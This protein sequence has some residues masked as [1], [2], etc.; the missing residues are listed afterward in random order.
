MSLLS[1]HDIEKSYGAHQVLKGISVTLAAG[2]R[3]GIVGN[4]GSGKTTLAR[5]LGKIEP[6][7]VGVVMQ[8]RGSRIGYLAQVP[9]LD[10][11]ATVRDTAL[12]GLAEFTA[13]RREHESVSRALEQLAER[14][15]EAPSAGPSSESL[16]ER[17]AELDAGIERMGGWAQEH[18][19]NS[20]LERLHVNQLDALIGT[21]SGGERRRVALC[22][23]LVSEPDVL[24]LDEPT[25]HLDTDSIDWLEEYLVDAYKGGVVVITHDRYFLDRVV[26]R[27][28]EVDAGRLQSYDGG[29]EAYLTAKAERQALEARTESNRQNFLRTE[30]EWLRR[31][32]KA[33][34]T[35]QKARIQ[36]AETAIG[37]G[38]RGGPQSLLF[39]ATSRRQGS[40][41]LEFSKVKAGY[42][43]RVLI[44]GLDLIVTPGQR[45]GV[46][47]PN[48]A[49]KTT[50]LAL[51]TQTLA[52]TSGGVRLGKNTRVGY[53]AQTRRELD[54]ALSVAENVAGLRT[55]LTVA[56]REITIYSYLE[57]FLFRG[58]EI[59]KKVGVLSGGE[60]ARV[61][62]AKLLLTP[63]NLLLLDEPTN[64]LDTT[65]LGALEQMMCEFPGSVFVV[66]HD[67]YFLDRVAT[68]ILVFEGE[69]KIGH[70][71]GDYAS[72][73][74]LRAERARLTASATAAASR[75]AKLQK[76]EERRTAKLSYKEQKEL[77][78]IEGVI[79]AAEREVQRVEGALA[80]PDLY[81][82]DPAKAAALGAE[83][84]VAQ[85]RVQTLMNRWQALE[86]KRE[87][88]A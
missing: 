87:G 70:Y 47:G 55:T 61:A 45:I 18:R 63:A 72:Y 44:D 6:P 10:E 7:D 86:H 17:M 81:R 64:D 21:L 49:G 85:A 15:G 56:G 43:E 2:E 37:D 8:Q 60:R 83:L 84:S 25:N 52:P 73:S 66:T 76:S 24:I 53:F 50:L 26:Q 74:R 58:E 32:P 22:A 13:A 19:A 40:E 68:S 23:L 29:W 82:R 3:V 31:Q 27:T 48:G 28:W 78:E 14:S 65:T 57:R 79:G 38:P 33:R 39:E 20:I 46:I 9:D 5:V 4:N 88:G 54:D 12:A 1:A 62:L 69:G 35:K 11:N 42:G 59:R 80:D 36:R 51:I 77:D 75:E 41:V 34:G 71:I 16:I 67:R 30:L